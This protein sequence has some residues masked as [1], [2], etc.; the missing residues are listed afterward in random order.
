MI[1]KLKYLPAIEDFLIE[2]PSVQEVRKR[3]YVSQESLDQFVKKYGFHPCETDPFFEIYTWSS[4][5]KIQYL[6]SIP[7]SIENIENAI[8]FLIQVNSP[9]ISQV[10]DLLESD[11]EKLK[12]DQKNSARSLGI[13]IKGGPRTDFFFNELIFNLAHLLK[14]KGKVSWKDVLFIIYWHLQNRIYL[15]GTD[16]PQFGSLLTST[17]PDN[18]RSRFHDY[19]KIK[20][21]PEAAVMKLIANIK[22][23]IT[24]T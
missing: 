1:S 20:S 14:Q 3:N 7:V 2:K 22:K 21:F 19:K 24:V 11:L 16:M 8:H 15:S 9:N 10:Q 18:L 12:N 17:K 23:K 4:T 5:R 13:N 6:K